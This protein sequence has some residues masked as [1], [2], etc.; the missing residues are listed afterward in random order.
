MLS[1]G[2]TVKGAY[3]VIAITMAT[4]HYEFSLKRASKTHF[5]PIILKTHLVNY[6]SFFFNLEN[7]SN[8]LF[9]LTL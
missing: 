3:D 8:F 2:N 5:S 1:S 7:T 4:G 6:L 9:F